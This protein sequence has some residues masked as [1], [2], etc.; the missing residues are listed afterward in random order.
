MLGRVSDALFFVGVISINLIVSVVQKIH[1]KHV[2]DQI[3][4]IAQPMISVI[5]EGMQNG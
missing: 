4:L 1:A 2:L 3:A 5:L